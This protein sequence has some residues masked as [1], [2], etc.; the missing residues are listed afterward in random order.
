MN[1]HIDKIYLWF[2]PNAK[3]CITFENNKVNVIRGNSSRGKSNLF[4]IIDYCLMS[5]KPNIV[6]PIINECTEAYGLEFVLNDTFY[7]VSR[8]K[9]E[10][11]TASQCV[12]VQNKS[13]T[14]D[15]YPNGTSN[16]KP[17]DFRRQLDIKS[18]LTEEYIYP[19]GVYKGEPNFV[20]SFRSFLMFNALTENI[21]SSQ[22]E[23]L[24]Y[25]FFEDEYVESKDKRA[26][27]IDVLLGI[28][29]VEER[30]QKEAIAI[31]DKT[32]RSSQIKIT[33]YNKCIQKYNQYRNSVE[34]LLR[35]INKTSG[36]EY[37]KLEGVEFLE[38]IKD[39]LRKYM[40]HQDKEIEKNATQISDL[41]T[42]LYRKKMLLFNIKRAQAEYSKYMEEISSVNESLKPVVYLNRHL[43]EYGVTIWGQHILDELKISLSKLRS[44]KIS[45]ESASIVS[46]KNVENLEQEISECEN[47]LKVLSEVKLRPVEQSSLYLALGQLKSLLPI[48]TDLQNQI[49]VKVPSDY[50][51]VSDKQIRDHA[52][53]ILSK[54][55]AR[56][57]FVVRGVFDKYIQGVYDALSVKDN[58]EN[59]KTRFNREKERLELSDGKSILNYS[60][61]GSQSNYMYLHICFFLGMHNFLLDNPCKQVGN[62]LFIDQP[63]V[64]YYENSDEDK[65]NDKAKLLDV[66]KVI[67]AFMENR[68]RKGNEFQII[69]IE[70]AEESYWTGENALS[71]FLTRANFDGD[72]ALVP[73]Q[74]IREY[75]NEN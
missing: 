24:N 48:L 25:K 58:F 61:I 27:L 45:K 70:H 18:G 22:Y 9:P 23:F 15:Y 33:K 43:S 7:A 62:F 65:S 30:K 11:G 68:I 31:L 63:S 47:Q 49:P 13:F 12:W 29:N 20:V 8:M 17:F 71:T 32:K 64:P 4:A 1:F 5:D 73:Q 10:A 26:Y 54:I 56:R 40:P 57:S 69:L 35:E 75:R 67:N 72:E 74:V 66:F 19:W 39:I 6:E 38:F 51:C 55:E 3:R 16:I 59:C 37:D 53:M 36:I 28:D 52:N 50:D 21:I 34:K 60:N 42:E 2:S 41:S 46:D 44:K 14:D